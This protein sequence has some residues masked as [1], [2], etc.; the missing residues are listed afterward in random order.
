VWIGLLAGISPLIAGQVL[1]LTAD[2]KG[3]WHYLGINPWTPLFFCGVVGVI[4]AVIAMAKLPSTGSVTVTTFAGMFFQG[5]PI[6][7]LQALYFYDRGGKETERV[8]AIKRIGS[9]R[10]PL[11]V[12]EFIDALRDPSFNVRYEAV[13]EIARSAPH[14]RLTEA[15]VKVLEGD[16]PDLATTAA[17]AL[18]R[19]EDKAGVP[20]LIRAL[21]STHRLIRTRSARALAMQRAREASPAILKL[22][23]EEQD[24]S[25]ALAYAAALGGVAGEEALPS[26]LDFLRRLESEKARLEVALSI[27]TILGQDD[28]AVKLWRRMYA[29]PGDALAGVIVGLRRRLPALVPHLPP[30]FKTLDHVIERAARAFGSNDIARGTSELRVLAAAVDPDHL[31]PGAAVVLWEAITAMD[32]HGP[33]RMEYVTLC[34]HAMHVGT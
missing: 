30:G 9:T 19:I 14:P 22:F 15:L 31:T 6:A 24:Q 10:S 27:A 33:K 11:V 17:W 26:L 34:V 32:E 13:I 3:D 7:A 21:E 20:A 1:K 12:D 23:H 28:R 5:N 2:F 16:E 8:A 25:L 18:G 29:D 4:G